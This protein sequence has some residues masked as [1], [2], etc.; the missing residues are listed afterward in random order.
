MP[1]VYMLIGLPG[2]GKSTWIAQQPLDWNNTVL[3]ST[4]NIIEQRA[5]VQGK[6]YTQVFQQEIK[7]ATHLM[8]RILQRA[9]V[10]NKDVVWDQTNISVNARKGK[11]TQFPSTYEKIG[12]FFVTPD[13][14]EHQRRLASR[15]GKI[16]PDDVIQ[17]MKAQLHA[18]SEAEGFDQILYVY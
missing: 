3:V 12:V 16:I 4:D 13:D 5:H 10:D 1:K 11:L 7:S 6:T 9:I 17:N 8:N 18:P 2:V 14:K 15:P